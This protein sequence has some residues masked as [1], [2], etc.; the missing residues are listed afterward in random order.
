MANL[1]TFNM[2]VASSEVVVVVCHRDGDFKNVSRE[3]KG[4]STLTKTVGP[5]QSI[6]QNNELF[7]N[8]T[9]CPPY[10]RT[11]T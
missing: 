6:S 2:Q 7:D 8:L 11:L 9:F 10:S 1:A 4:R 5:W 3:Q